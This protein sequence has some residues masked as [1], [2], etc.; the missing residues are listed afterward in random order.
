[1]DNLLKLVVGT[2]CAFLMIHISYRVGYNHR[3]EFSD[4]KAITGHKIEVKYQTNSLGEVKI[5]SK[6]WVKN[7]K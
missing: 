7:E 4:N 1:M 2:I 6:N 3:M 5:V